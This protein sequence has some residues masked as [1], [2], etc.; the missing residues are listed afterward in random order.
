MPGP[1]SPRHL[2]PAVPR[3]L[4]AVCLLCLKKDPARRFR[5]AHDLAFALEALSDSGMTTSTGGH[6]SI[7]EP[8]SRRGIAI[9]GA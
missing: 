5:T 1:L 2:A 9:A 3:D 7:S 8:T 4:E 6:P